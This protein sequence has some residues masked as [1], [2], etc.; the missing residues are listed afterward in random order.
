MDFITF[1]HFIKKDNINKNIEIRRSNL[2]NYFGD[3]DIAYHVI[4]ITRARALKNADLRAVT[5]KSFFF[6]LT[7]FCIRSTFNHPIC[8]LANENVIAQRWK[9][10]EDFTA[11]SMD[12]DSSLHD[13]VRSGWRQLLFWMTWDRIIVFDEQ[14]TVFCIWWTTAKRWKKY[15]S[16]GRVCV[17]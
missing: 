6:P 4:G 10:L 14:K 16:E 8:V 3:M 1:C 5:R 12:F 11:E 15:N 9:V 7:K 17:V 13:V 2:T